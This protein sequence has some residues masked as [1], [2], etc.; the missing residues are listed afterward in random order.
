MMQEAAGAASPV[1]SGGKFSGI[2]GA[3]KSAGEKTYSVGQYN[4]S[5]ERRV[6]A[7]PRV[8]VQGVIT[9]LQVRGRAAYLTLAEFA[10]GDAKP[11][12]VLDVMLWAAELEYFNARFAQLATPFTLRPELKV[13]VLLESSFYVPTGRFQPHV[14][15][16]DEFFTLGELSL[17]RRKTLERLQQAGLLDRNKRL[18]LSEVPLRLGLISA[19][20]SAA[21]QDFT[22][23]LLQSGFAFQIFFAPARMQGPATEDTVT[24]ALGALARHGLDAICIVRGGG[25]KTDLVYFDSEKI[26][27]AIA[28]CP[29]PVL[30]GIG[31]EIDRA[32]AD[33]V[34]H[35]DLITPTD[36]AKF[37]EGRVEDAWQD[38][39]RKA[40]LVR[41]TWALVY[42]ETGYT[43]IRQAQALRAA[44]EGQARR[45]GLRQSAAY[46]AAVAGSG[47]LLRAA[48]DH[49]RQN[50]TGLLRGPNKLTRLEHL[51]FLN[52]AGLLHKTWEVWR[53][54]QRGLLAL[55]RSRL[56][57]AWLHAARRTQDRLD[58]QEKLAQSADPVRL[59]RRG[60]ALVYDKAGRLLSGAE[61][62]APGQ[63]LR[64]RFWDGAVL[65]RVHGKE[66]SE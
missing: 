43:A 51:R 4:R 2:S 24:A 28:L 15:E 3:E 47:R 38:L 61:A 26:C 25:S 27:R 14:K 40:E 42:Q 57:Q 41:E 31:H 36:C 55:G 19:P 7:F 44:W 54:Q 17:T 22:T 34:A 39:H 64:T 11:K 49:G 30:T 46:H 13:S 23:T 33:V 32:L 65:S 56:T 59:L 53:A 18:I 62:V 8:W 5:V 35:A 21:Y 6:K 52:R 20:G 9:Q 58:S 12:A 45:E 60:Y 48:R 16:V 10:E 1:D 63:E 50:L 37:L 29:V 66:K